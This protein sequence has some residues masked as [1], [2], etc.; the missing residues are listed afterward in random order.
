MYTF[1]MLN[2]YVHFK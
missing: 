2:T 1:S